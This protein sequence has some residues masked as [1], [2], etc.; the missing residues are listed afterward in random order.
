VRNRL[1]VVFDGQ[2]GHFGNEQT[3]EVKVIFTQGENADACIKTIVDHAKDPKAFVVVSDDKEIKLYTRA[4]GAKV[5]SVKEFA[6]D[7]FGGQAQKKSGK[8]SGST[9]KVTLTQA[10]KINKE[11]EKLWLK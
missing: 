2:S 10:D 11:L 4:L 8:T 7:L 5:M 9:Q 6:A 1:T 3:G